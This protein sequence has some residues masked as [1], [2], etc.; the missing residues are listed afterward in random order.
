MSMNEVFLYLLFASV[1][2]FRGLSTSHTFKVTCDR[3]VP[4]VEK[5]TLSQVA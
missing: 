2:K 4:L 1:D 5:N 3:D